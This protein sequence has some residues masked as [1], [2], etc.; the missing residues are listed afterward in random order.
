MRSKPTTVVDRGIDVPSTWQVPSDD[1]HG[2]WNSY[3]GGAKS[4]NDDLDKEHVQMYVVDVSFTR[5]KER[6]SP[7]RAI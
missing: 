7:S 5:C 1:A 6:T 3:G 4:K 2:G